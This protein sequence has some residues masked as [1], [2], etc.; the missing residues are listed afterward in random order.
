MTINRY[1]VPFLCQ[2]SPSLSF[3][4]FI[5]TQGNWTALLCWLCFRSL[6]MNFPLFTQFECWDLNSYKTTPF[7]TALTSSIPQ[8][9][10]IVSTFN[11]AHSQPHSQNIYTS[12][13]TLIS[14]QAHFHR[15]I[16]IITPKTHD[17]VT[18][19]ERGDILGIKTFQSRSTRTTIPK[20]TTS[21]L[22]QRLCYWLVPWL[23]PPSMHT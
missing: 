3:V 6:L 13:L 2:H 5:E 12:P 15:N 19:L 18:R 1:I 11:F 22:P 17:I 7:P 14:W 21:C 20:K 9:H 4:L 23:F 16:T 8:A 10:Q